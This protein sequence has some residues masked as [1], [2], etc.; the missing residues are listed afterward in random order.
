MK[1]LFAYSNIVRIFANT[2][3]E[4]MSPK[5]YT[6]QEEQLA[7]FAKAMGHPARMAIL[8]FLAGQ[9]SSR[10]FSANAGRKIPVAVET[11]FF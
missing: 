5:A 6:E 3:S 4:N 9:E 7:R 11:A 2:R 8:R 10:I 1:K